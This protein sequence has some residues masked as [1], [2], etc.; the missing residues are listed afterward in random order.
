M[1]VTFNFRRG[2]AGVMFT[3]RWGG[4]GGVTFNFCR[5]GRGGGDF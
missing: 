2:R 5:V 4:A 3:F 1:G